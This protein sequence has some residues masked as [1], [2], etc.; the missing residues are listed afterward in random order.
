MKLKRYR[1]FAMSTPREI[2]ATSFHLRDSSCIFGGQCKLIPLAMKQRMSSFDAASG[3]SVLRHEQQLPKKHKE[4]TLTLP[5]TNI[6]GDGTCLV[7]G[8]HG[9]VVFLVPFDGWRNRSGLRVARVSDGL[10]VLGSFTQVLGVASR[11]LIMATLR[12]PNRSTCL[13]TAT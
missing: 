6:Q 2:A 13:Q 7:F 10:T 9:Q 1:S 11:S 12:E 8:F 5:Q 3:R 4:T